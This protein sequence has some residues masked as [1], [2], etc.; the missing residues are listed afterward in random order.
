MFYDGDGNRVAETV[1]ST[2]TKYLVDTLNPTGY[3]QVVDE[4]VN[5]SVT[6]TFTY[7]LRPISENQL[8]GSTWTP[9]FYGYDGHGNVRF[10]ANTAGTLSDNYQFDAFG[11]SIATSGSTSNP[12]RYSGERFDSALNLYHLR[13]RYYNML[14]GRFET[15]DP[16]AGKVTD[17][18][19]LHRYVYSANNPVNLVDPTGR[20]AVAERVEVVHINEREGWLGAANAIGTCDKKSIEAIGGAQGGSATGD[21]SNNILECIIEFELDVTGWPQ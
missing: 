3:S 15:M 21:V 9:S 12:Y 20:D 6:R 10:L 13:A 8:V 1:G 7:G 5:G 16:Y 17:P 14:T 18:R 19:T 2:T 11:M 4:V